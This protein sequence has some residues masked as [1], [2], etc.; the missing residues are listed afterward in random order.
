MVDISYCFLE[1]FEYYCLFHHLLNFPHG[2]VFVANFNNLFIFFDDLFDSLHNDGNLD[3][4]FHDVLNV[5][6]DVDEL[7]DNSFHFN[8]ARDFH[9][10][11]FN[12]FN[13]IDL[14]DDD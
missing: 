8:N 5:F 13:F 6:V 3:D 7:R 9:Q 14:R 1:L 11:F 2:C 4:L 12:S 10:F